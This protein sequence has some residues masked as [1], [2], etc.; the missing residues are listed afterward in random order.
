MMSEI[1]SEKEPVGGPV[2]SEAAVL[3]EEV[4][5][6]GHLESAL[7]AFEAVAEL[8]PGMPTVDLSVALLH[9][10]LA[11]VAEGLVDITRALIAAENRGGTG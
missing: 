9:A 5:V 7:K 8:S 11:L 1:S 2:L 10:R 6:D 3:K 4:G